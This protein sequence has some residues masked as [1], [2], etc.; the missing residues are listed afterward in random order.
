MFFSSCKFLPSSL[1]FLL[2]LSLFLIFVL[3][4][5]LF[6]FF[7]CPSLYAAQ[8]TLFPKKPTTRIVWNKKATQTNLSDVAT[9]WV[10]SEVKG[11]K[12]AVRAQF[13]ILVPCSRVA[14]QFP[15]L[16]LYEH[17]LIYSRY[18]ICTIHPTKIDLMKWLY[19]PFCMAK[20]TNKSS[21]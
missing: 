2:V 12:S 11:K 8:F 10:R 15:R 21:M 19:G 13:T 14:V 6:F 9:K 20:F 18:T 7:F 4:I 3:F 5:S 1:S 16:I 17:F